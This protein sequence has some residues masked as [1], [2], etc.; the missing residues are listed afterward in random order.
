MITLY[1]GLP[2]QYE[3]P[4]LLCVITCWPRIA[5]AIEIRSNIYESAIKEDVG[6]GSE[7]DGNMYLNQ[8]SCGFQ[9]LYDSCGYFAVSKTDRGVNCVYDKHKLPRGQWD[10]YSN[11]QGK[12]VRKYK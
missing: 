10:I 1:V 11:P 4:L 8:L 7:Y 9:C 3:I 12:H 5:V 6:N 2:Q